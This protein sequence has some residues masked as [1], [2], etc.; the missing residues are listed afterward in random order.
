MLMAK[1][2]NPPLLEEFVAYIKDN[3]LAIS[4]PEGLYQGY[5]DGGWIDTR[6]NMIRNWK[7][8][9]HTLNNFSKP[10]AKKKLFP[11]KGKSCEVKQCNLPAVYTTSLGGAYDHYFCQI[12]MPDNV[13][14]YYE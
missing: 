13:K 12:H 1:K 8:K 9:L 14:Q 4:N 6:G 5:S 10:Q 3:K 11:I 2:F 7:L